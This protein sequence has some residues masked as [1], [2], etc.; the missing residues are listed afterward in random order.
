MLIIA[1]SLMMH[2]AEFDKQYFWKIFNKVFPL[3][4]T[5]LSEENF[6][7]HKIIFGNTGIFKLLET[8][9]GTKAFDWQKSP[10]IGK[11]INLNLIMKMGKK[12]ALF[13]ILIFI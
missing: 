8:P 1:W 11:L 3:N 13:Q 6:K 4:R 9:T 7:S 2:F 10:K 12:F 5:L